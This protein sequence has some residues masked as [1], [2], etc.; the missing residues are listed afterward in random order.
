[1]TVR[2]LWVEDRMRAPCW[3]ERETPGAEGRGQREGNSA[4]ILEGKRDSVSLGRSWADTAGG[5]E[6]FSD[7][8]SLSRKR[9]LFVIMHLLLP[10]PHPLM[11][12]NKDQ[13]GVPLD[14]IQP[15]ASSQVYFS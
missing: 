5:R 14:P 11:E 15:Q 12:I 3:L 8:V 1:M 6:S 2:F 9:G 10:L 7:P 4:E 13:T